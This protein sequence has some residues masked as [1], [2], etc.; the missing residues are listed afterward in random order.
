MHIATFE[1][2]EKAQFTPAQVK[3]IAQAVEEGQT[4]LKQQFV[5]KEAF[6]IHRQQLATR[7]DL[8]KI[9]GEL[10]QWMVGLM[11]AQFGMAVALF[12][13]FFHT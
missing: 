1:L 7:E 8:Y 10:I 2:L 6:E 11:L 13:L 4:A 3:A 12:K 9:K 5:T